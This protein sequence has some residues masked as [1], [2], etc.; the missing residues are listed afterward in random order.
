MTLFKRFFSEPEDSYFLF[1]PRGTGKTTFIKLRYPDAITIDLINPLMLRE[2]LARPERLKDVIL[3]NPN[4]KTVL[5]DE[6]Q[7]APALL[8][9]VHGLIEEKMGLK[10]ILTGSSSRKLKHSGADLLA[11]RAVKRM[12]HPFMAAEMNH[13]FNLERALQEGMIPLVCESKSP[14]NVLQTYVN[15]YLQE[16]I[17]SEGLVRNLESFARFLESVSFSH[18]SLLNVT[19][20]ARESEVKRKTVENYI[21]ILEELLLAVRIPV[22]T[23]RA[24]RQLV[25]HPKFYLFDSGVFSALRP[26]GPFDKPEEI[27]GAALE[28]LVAQHLLAWIDYNE[29]KNDLFYWRTPAGLEVDFVIYGENALIAIEV[30]NGM[31]VHPKDIKG[32]QAFKMDYPMAKAIL[33]YRGHERIMQNDVLCIPCEDFLKNLNPKNKILV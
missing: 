15:L 9:C 5:I 7:K 1:G 17:Q 23:K 3:A 22:F 27:E 24:S 30:K 31:R 16:E 10:F 12:L 2:Y 20:V 29:E 13:E 6:V 33:L 28:G 11:G 32:L 4:K 8:S 14:K 21:E 26:K 25:S 18:G 19:N